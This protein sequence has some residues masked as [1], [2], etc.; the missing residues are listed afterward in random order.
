[1]SALRKFH[2]S[3]A[4]TSPTGYETTHKV[5]LQALNSIYRY[6]NSNNDDDNISIVVAS[7]S[8]VFHVRRVLTRLGI[9]LTV[10]IMSC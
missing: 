10:T 2:T 4:N 5:A 6:S 7:N 1:M 3:H 9:T 8:P